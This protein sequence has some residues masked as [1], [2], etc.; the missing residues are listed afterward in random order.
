M[1]T[2]YFNGKPDALAA[3]QVLQDLGFKSVVHRCT[4]ET[5]TETVVAQLKR[6]NCEVAY[7]SN[8]D[9]VLGSLS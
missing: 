8:C 5:Y 4:T 9:R 3:A 2:A 6:Q 7:D 1:R